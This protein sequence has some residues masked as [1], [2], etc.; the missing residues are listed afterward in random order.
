M[1]DGT[2]QVNGYRWSITFDSNGWVDPTTH[3][4]NVYAASNWQ[5]SAAR[6]D[7]VWGADADA[8]AF[9]K[10]WGK[11]VGNMPALS[12][13]RSSAGL[14]PDGRWH[15]EVRRNHGGGHKALGWH[16]HHHSGLDRAGTLPLVRLLRST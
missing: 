11:N 13:V 14:E 9:S 8:E 6:R 16:V 4:T 12:C 5:G 3:A 1:N 7:D 15:P 10:A 2:K